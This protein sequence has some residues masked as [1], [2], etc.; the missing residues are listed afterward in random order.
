LLVNG[1][2]SYFYLEKLRGSLIKDIPQIFLGDHG[3]HL[4][5]RNRRRRRRRRRKW[6]YNV[7][8]NLCLSFFSMTELQE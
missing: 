1:F 6:R 7:I 5:S 8:L 2:W 4:T 3:S